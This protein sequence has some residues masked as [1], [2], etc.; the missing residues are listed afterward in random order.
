MS[1]EIHRKQAVFCNYGKFAY[2][3][4]RNCSETLF[5]PS[6]DVSLFIDFLPSAGDSLSALIFY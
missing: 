6:K 5:T 4:E 2:F 3:I 1:R